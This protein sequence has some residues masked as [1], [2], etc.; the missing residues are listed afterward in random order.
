[1]TH[2]QRTFTVVGISIVAASIASYGVYRAVSRIPVRNVEIA[3]NWA[4]VAARPLPT[5]ARI[6]AKDVKR[7]AWP[8]R[9]PVVGG[10]SEVDA[11]V[12]RGL[13]ASVFENEPLV[14]GKLA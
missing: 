12:G 6:E 9:S 5:G 8:A 11:V 7:V 2:Q 10:F 3:T 14:E 1:M 4:V 13:L